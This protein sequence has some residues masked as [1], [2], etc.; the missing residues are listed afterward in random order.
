[1]KNLSL[2]ILLLVI[3][4]VIAL[5]VDSVQGQTLEDQSDTFL[6]F[7]ASYASIYQFETDLQNQGSFDVSRQ[8]IKVGIMGTLS[9][10]ITTGLE[11][12]VEIDEWDFGNL[13]TVAGATPWDTVDQYGISLPIYYAFNENWTL[14]MIPTAKFSGESGAEVNDSVIYGGSVLLNH[15]HSR[16]LQF[17]I[18]FSAFD[19]L[20]ETVFAP[21]LLIN[22]QVNDQWRV[23]NPFVAGPA[24]PAGLEIVYSP[25][26]NWEFAMG[27]AYRHYR[28]RLSEENAVSNGVGQNESVVAFLRLQ[29]KLGTMMTLDVYG[30]ALFDGELSIEDSNG[31]HFSSEEYDLAPMVALQFKCKF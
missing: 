27:G 14:G 13:S 31:D 7:S 29:R 25:T 2:F 8:S 21:F 6:S 11:L 16:D 28:F 15:I 22:W 18:G 10:R 5:P 17:G 12:S 19:Q 26:D 24:G 4:Q 20:E 3:V 23:S 30:G 1:M 9:P